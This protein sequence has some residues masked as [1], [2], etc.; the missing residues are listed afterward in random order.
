MN[1]VFL[2]TPIALPPLPEV[3]REE[4]HAAGPTQRQWLHERVARRAAA[5]RDDVARVVDELLRAGDLVAGHGLVGPAPLRAVPLPDGGA[6]IV[7]SRPD[8]FLSVETTDEV[9]RRAAS[10]PNDALEVPLERW[11]GLDRS[12]P[13]GPEFLAALTHKDVDDDGEDWSGA[14]GWRDGRFRPDPTSPGVWRLRMPGGWFRYAWVDER[15]RRP[16]TPH[17][18]LRAS[19]ALAR[20]N[21]GTSVAA[22]M[23]DGSVVV[24]LPRLPR[25]E[26]RFVAA[27]AARSPDWSWHIP[28]ARWDEVR[29]TLGQ[30]LGMHFEVSNGEA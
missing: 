10:I 27:C 20:A 19:F 16:L 30:R 24:K 1:I 26:Y 12:P 2:D 25:A 21:G 7:G 6:L 28:A 11:A 14:Y 4:A 8:R 18:G 5:E 9:P 22:Q 23:T 29:D 3:V 17:D 13:A 15:G